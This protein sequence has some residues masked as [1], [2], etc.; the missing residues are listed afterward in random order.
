MGSESFDHHCK[1]CE[2]DESGD[3][4]HHSEAEIS[5]SKS[6]NR[7]CE[8]ESDEISMSTTHG[9]RHMNKCYSRYFHFIIRFFLLNILHYSTFVELQSETNLSFLQSLIAL[10]CSYARSWAVG[11]PKTKR[12]LCKFFLLY[13]WSKCI[14]WLLF[15]KQI[16]S[17]TL[18]KK[19][20]YLEQFFNL[21]FLI[22]CIFLACWLTTASFFAFYFP[23]FFSYRV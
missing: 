9:L 19:K 12:S 18:W 11:V 10:L 15:G 13:Y 20:I 3:E 6:P 23:F 7:D 14:A 16:Y 17:A 21:I 2:D 8:S 1:K 5:I 22:K 4:Y